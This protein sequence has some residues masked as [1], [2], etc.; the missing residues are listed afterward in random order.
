LLLFIVISV[1][2]F[3]YPRQHLQMLLDTKVKSEQDPSMLAGGQRT[4]SNSDVFT[5]AYA[6][7]A[8]YNS[9][10]KGGRSG[11]G[12]GSR[13]GGGGGRGEVMSMDKGYDNN[14]EY[15]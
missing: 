7:S 3:S 11:S 8:N 2:S 12:G 15:Y 1:L 10:S 14:E 9:D 6:E 4:N 5:P 13:G